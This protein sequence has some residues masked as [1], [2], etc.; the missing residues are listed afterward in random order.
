MVVRLV[1]VDG[2]KWWRGAAEEGL[3]ADKSGERGMSQT[4][5]QVSR[6]AAPPPSESGGGYC[7]VTRDARDNAHLR[8]VKVRDDSITRLS[9]GLGL[10]ECGRASE[11]R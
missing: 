3:D 6:R 10:H 7:R 9:G 8:R 2:S 11:E 4:G 5:H 1:C